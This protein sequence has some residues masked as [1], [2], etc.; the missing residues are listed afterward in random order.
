[1]SQVIH[2]ICQMCRIK[3]IFVSC[4]RYTAGVTFITCF[5]YHILRCHKCSS[6]VN[7]STVRNLQDDSHSSPVTCV[8]D[9]THPDNCAVHSGIR[10]GRWL[11]VQGPIRTLLAQPSRAPLPAIGILVWRLSPDLRVQCLVG[12]THA[13]WACPSVWRLEQTS[14][15]PETKSV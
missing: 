1:M 13:K 11:H 2:F 9:A 12:E 6:C 8:K 10:G 7:C 15:L 4:Q 5:S 14:L 3:V